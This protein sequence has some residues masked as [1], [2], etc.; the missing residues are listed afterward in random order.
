MNRKTNIVLTIVLTAVIAVSMTACGSSAKNEGE[1]ESKL[2]DISYSEEVSSESEIAVMDREENTEPESMGTDNTEI[3]ADDDTASVADS[4]KNEDSDSDVF[5]DSETNSDDSGNK[6]N[7]GS[8]NGNSNNKGNKE[9]PVSDEHIFEYFSI[10]GNNFTVCGSTID[11]LDSLKGEMYFRAEEDTSLNYDGYFKDRGDFTRGYWGSGKNSTKFFLETDSDGNITAIVM[12]DL[13]GN[14]AVAIRVGNEGVI[15]LGL[16]QD[17]IINE[18]TT[19][20]DFEA[21]EMLFGK[22]DILPTENEIDYLCVYRDRYATMTLLV[23]GES[24]YQNIKEIMIKR[25]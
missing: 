24:R 16:S 11:R 19:I 21:R 9:Q 22:G 10:C 7:G 25:N 6:D 23:D 4:D 12:T 13:K 18:D 14:D 1:A 2:P 15:K 3:E 17:I 8:G 5:Y 20:A